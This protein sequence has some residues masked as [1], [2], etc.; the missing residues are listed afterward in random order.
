MDVP[1]KEHLIEKI[2]Y[3]HKS[4]YFIR[5]RKATHPQLHALLH[6]GFIHVIRYALNLS[7]PI[8]TVT[9]HHMT[10]A[11]PAAEDP[12]LTYLHSL[13]GPSKRYSRPACAFTDL[14]ATVQGILRDD[15]SPH[16]SIPGPLTAITE[17]TPSSLSVSEDKFK[18]LF[19]A[20]FGHAYKALLRN[21]HTILEPSPSLPQDKSHG[22]QQRSGNESQSKRDTDEDGP[23]SP[24]PL[25]QPLVKPLRWIPPVELPRPALRLHPP[26]LPP[27][28]LSQPVQSLRHR[29]RVPPST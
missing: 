11:L 14:S 7:I 13:G 6:D 20:I 15:M 17:S 21:V 19:K 18:D 3:C 25:P 24:P 16:H 28:G 23:S 8:G 1:W 29:R 27:P 12:A 2:S 22:D 10:P 26:L 4:G 9:F 5:G